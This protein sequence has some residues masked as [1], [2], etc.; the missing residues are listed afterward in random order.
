MWRY[1]PGA[2]KPMKRTIPIQTEAERKLYHADY[3]QNKR[4]RSFN[5]DWTKNRPWL[6]YTDQG[7]QCKSE[8]EPT[9][10]TLSC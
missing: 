5:K 10:L 3:E 2:K 7:M 6:I 1:I 8:Y 9:G 4:K